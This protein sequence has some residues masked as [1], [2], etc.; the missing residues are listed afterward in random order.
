MHDAVVIATEGETTG[1]QLI[2]YHVGDS[3]V[4]VQTLK[5]HLAAA[6]PDYMVPAAY[7][8]LDALPLTPNG[9][10]DRNA[11]PKPDIGALAVKAYAAP[12]GQVEETLA[13]VW[14]DLLAVERVGRHDNFFS[15]GGNSLLVI[16]LISQLRASGI[17]LS[18]AQI[19]ANPTIMTLAESH[20]APADDM[21][22]NIV[23]LRS[24]GSELPL[25]LVHEVSGE[26]IYGPELTRHIDTDIPVFGLT[27][28]A[29]DDAPQL[30]LIHI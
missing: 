21:P 13:S 19:L 18:V 5:D 11:L 12:V 10:L 22:A 1:Q 2:A 16:Q 17:D 3:E 24:T 9:K 29:I 7:V 8:A 15:L 25:F 6:L 4:S 28:Y 30:S 14:S 20:I 26:M 27:S 23:S